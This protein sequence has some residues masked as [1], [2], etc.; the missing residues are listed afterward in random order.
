MDWGYQYQYILS[1]QPTLSTQPT[2]A[3]HPHNPPMSSP[4]QL[5]LENTT[6]DMYK[7]DRKGGQ[8]L[9]HC[10]TGLHVVNCTQNQEMDQ[11]AAAAAATATTPSHTLTPT[12]PKS[13]PTHRSPITSNHPHPHH[14]PVISSPRRVQHRVLNG[15]LVARRD[16]PSIHPTPSRIRP[17]Q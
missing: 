13:H 8:W 10:N 17:G 14:A 9:P 16:T 2:L 12:P 3:T 11:A 7:F 4:Q 6:G 15:H 5:W 1:S